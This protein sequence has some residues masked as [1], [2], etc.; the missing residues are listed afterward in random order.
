MDSLPI[1]AENVIW[2]WNYPPRYRPKSANSGRQRRFL[3]GV[4]PI[5]TG[6]WAL[7]GVFSGATVQNKPKVGVS[8]LAAGCY[9]DKCLVSEEGPIQAK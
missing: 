5:F 3:G 2:P 6:M 1:I 8:G 4:T 9:F 7:H